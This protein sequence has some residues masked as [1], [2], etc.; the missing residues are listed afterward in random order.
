MTRLTTFLI[1][2]I[3]SSLT[4]CGSNIRINIPRPDDAHY[5]IRNVMIQGPAQIRQ[6]PTIYEV[7]FEVVVESDGGAVTPLVTL[8]DYDDGLRF[9]DDLLAQDSTQINPVPISRGTYSGRAFMEL[10]C[11][12]TFDVRGNQGSSDEG[13]RIGGVWPLDYVDEAEVYA[14]VSRADGS[15]EASSVTMDVDC[16]QP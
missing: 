4:G 2:I 1:F 12:Q 14:K 8:L 9:G 3:S 6:D 5:H 16:A 11:T 13:G 10:S 15:G 7:T